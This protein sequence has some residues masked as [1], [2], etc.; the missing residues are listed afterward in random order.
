MGSELSAKK[1]QR[2]DRF[3]FHLQG[4]AGPQCHIL[5]YH[6]ELNSEYPS[7]P[8]ILLA[9]EAVIWA[10]A[11]GG[12]DSVLIGGKAAVGILGPSLGF[13]KNHGFFPSSKEK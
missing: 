2:S 10:A 9:L 5:Q 8:L 3:S 7:C 6:E 12:P 13:S 4:I 11:P 1:C